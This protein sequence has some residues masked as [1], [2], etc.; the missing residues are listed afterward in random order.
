MRNSTR[1]FVRLL[2]L[3]CMASGFGFAA[4]WSG[5]LVDANC[6]RNMQQNHNL[7]ESPV[8][9]NVDLEIRACSPK[10]KTHV[11][12]IVQP[13]GVNVRLDANGNA[14]AAGLIR[15]TSHRAS[16]YVTVDGAMN[17]KT[18]AVNSITPSR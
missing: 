3:L 12:S 14:R 9:R 6:Y 18:I 17:G 7:S 10:S 16:L 1:P 4:T 13:N 8:V 11:F 15:Q 5:N 2:S